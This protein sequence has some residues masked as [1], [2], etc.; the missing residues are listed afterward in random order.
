MWCFPE[1]NLGPLATSLPYT[2]GSSGPDK[3]VLINESSG[4]NQ[5]KKTRDIFFWKVREPIIR[6]WT[7]KGKSQW[8]CAWSSDSCWC[9]GPSPKGG[10]QLHSLAQ[11]WHCDQC[12]HWWGGSWMSPVGGK[13]YQGAEGPIRTGHAHAEVSLLGPRGSGFLTGGFIYILYWARCAH[14]DLITKASSDTVVRWW[15]RC[16]RCSF[17]FVWEHAIFI[18]HECNKAFIWE[19]HSLLLSCGHTWRVGD[20]LGAMEYIAPIGLLNDFG[21]NVF[22]LPPEGGGYWLVGCFWKISCHKLILHICL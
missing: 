11:F 12:M 3:L 18:S 2:F 17:R 20:C 4:H 1:D 21:W 16:G 10:Y 7:W 6:Y 5:N 8:R 22:L 15:E 13:S 19:W 14:V 9:M